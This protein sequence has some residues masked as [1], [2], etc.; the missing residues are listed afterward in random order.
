MKEQRF[1]EF[2][3]KKKKRGVVKFCLIDGLLLWGVT[4]GLT[5]FLINIFLFSAPTTLEYFLKNLLSFAFGGGIFWGPLTWYFNEKKFIKL[6]NRDLSIKHL[7][8]N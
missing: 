7:I 2:W 1:L 8:N 6:C 4:T 5:V 3:N